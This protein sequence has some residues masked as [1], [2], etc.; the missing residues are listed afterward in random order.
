MHTMEIPFVFDNINRCKEIT[1]GDKA[2]IELADKISSAWIN[3]AKTGNPN[4]IGL[5]KWP[6]YTTDGGAIMIFNNQSVVMNHPDAELL[7]IAALK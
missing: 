7:K 4:A 2:A 1:G 3:F 6:A 5:P